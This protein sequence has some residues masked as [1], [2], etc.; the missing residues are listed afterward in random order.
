VNVYLDPLLNLFISQKYTLLFWLLVPASFYA[1]RHRRQ[2]GNDL[3]ALICGLGIVSFLFVAFNPKLYLVPRYFIL[4]AWCASVIVGWWL[5]A[6]W[7]ERRRTLFAM[8]ASGYML[9]SAVALSVE[10]IN[11]RFVER[12]L[13]AWISEHP[14]QSIHVDPETAKRSKYFFDFAGVS[15]DRVIVQR[16]P[17]GGLAFF[18]AD[19]VTQC[20]TL[21][22]CKERASDFVPGRGWTQLKV[23][24]ANPRLVGRILRV[25]G[26]APYLPRDVARRLLL[27]GGRIVIYSVD[28]AK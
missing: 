8:L 25:T 16:A 13:V 11:P 20:A 6:L 21:P 24:E 22:R 2:Q 9:A 18:S 5:A 4:C 15:M 19:R 27:P 12:Q 14:Q 26:V 17:P 1:W 28:V 10:N 3:L 23:I 7:R